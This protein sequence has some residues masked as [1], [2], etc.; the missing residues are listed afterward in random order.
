MYKIENNFV[1]QESSTIPKIPKILNNNIYLMKLTKF[2]H[3]SVYLYIIVAYISLFI[4]NNSYNKNS[5]CVQLLICDVKYNNQK[6]KLKF[7]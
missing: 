5:S 1:P 7:R 4:Y 6:L 2:I 3:I